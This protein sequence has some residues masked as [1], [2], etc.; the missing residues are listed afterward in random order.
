MNYKF[1]WV[2]SESGENVMQWILSP[3]VTVGRCPTAE[4]TIDDVS[5]SRRHCQFML[6]PYGSLMV[7][8]LGSKNG[9]FV[10]Q[11]K[12]DKAIVRPGDVVRLGM[13]ALR[14]ELTEEA[15]KPATTES[16]AKG[17]DLAETEALRI[18]RP[19]DDIYEIG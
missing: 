15:S 17:Y 11:R 3:P 9:V 8:D 4:I 18:V 5:I 12:V 7:R 6:D 2:D 1:V 13:V 19:D 14:A 10:D 16:N